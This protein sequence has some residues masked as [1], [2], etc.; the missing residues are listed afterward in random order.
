MPTSAAPAVPQLQAEE[1]KPS[2]RTIALLFVGL[3]VTMLMAS[4]SQ[5]ILSTALPTIVGQLG[6]VEQMT[7]VITGYILASTVMM[8][9]YGR[10]SDIVGR[11]PTLIA[12]IVLFM[13]GSVFGA[14]TTSIDLLV[15][16][17]V[18]QG[19]GGG[20]LMILSQAA[21]AEVVPARERGRYMGIMGAVFAVSSV[22]G[23]LVGGWLT[24]GPGWRWAFWLNIPLGVLAIVA[25]A[26]F[27]HLPR[28]VRTG[29]ARI[30]YL[31]MALIAAATVAIV[32]VC[33]WG[34]SEYVWASPQILGLIAAAVVL[35][36]LFVLVESKAEQPVIPLALFRNRSFVLATFSGLLTGIA[37]FGVLSYM[38]TYIQMVVGVSAT[39]AG[40]LMIPMM[41]GLLISSVISGQ[42]VTRTG[43]YKIFPLI[44]S[45]VMALG[46]WAISTMTIDTPTWVL[47]T[48]VG[49]FGIGLGLGQQILMLIVQDAFP[50][51]IV[52]TATAAF[53]YFKQVGATVGSAV[54]GA[55]FATRLTSLLTENMTAALSTASPEDLAAAGG[56]DAST[57]TPAAVLDLPSSIRIPIITSYNEALLP[58]VQWLVPL[59]LAVIVV[60]LFVKEKALSET[61]DRSAEETSI[62]AEDAPAVASAAL[63]EAVVDGDA[64][65]GAA[66]D[67][68]VREKVPATSGV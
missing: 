67:G 43:R 32:L 19:L 28:P 52:G 22:A 5:T 26:L 53:N 8:P 42:L 14:L 54:V 24:E 64:L 49:I 48:Y 3:M 58:I 56:L 39:V 40:L 35:G 18:I 36:G 68:A 17:R 55:V 46:L 29:R 10:V 1:A 11:K 57:L 15:V 9:V 33:T 30:D 50:V 59:A 41:G 38:P 13:I 65:D 6:G 61:I 37:M 23:P 66:R 44:G 63:E 25:V 47:C 7:W 16:A 31:G 60:M 20:G 4:L 21:I 62:I 2:G 51:R 34:G 45:A 12:A 27:L